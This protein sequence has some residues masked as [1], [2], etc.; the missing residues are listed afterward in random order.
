[1]TVL[2]VR[3]TSRRTLPG[4]RTAI[5]PFEADIRD[6]WHFRLEE[7]S[8][9]EDVIAMICIADGAPCASAKRGA[10]SQS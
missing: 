3:G 10:M 7:D 5:Y 8:T 9:D 2:M 4:I 1:M 6:Y